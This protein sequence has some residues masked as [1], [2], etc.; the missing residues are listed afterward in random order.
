MYSG[1]NPPGPVPSPILLIY[2]LGNIPIGT[3]VSETLFFVFQPTI[4][5]PVDEVTIW[6]VDTEKPQRSRL[7]TKRKAQWRTWMLKFGRLLPRERSVYV[8]AGNICAS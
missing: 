4:G 7:L 8:E 2:F 5:K 3:N 6:L 1:L